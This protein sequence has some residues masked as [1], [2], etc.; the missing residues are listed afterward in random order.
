[1]LDVYGAKYK[2]YGRVVGYLRP[3]QLEQRQ[4]RRICHVQRM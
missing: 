4:K 1:M 3:V 2:G